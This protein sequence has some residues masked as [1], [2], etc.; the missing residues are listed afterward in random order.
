MIKYNEYVACVCFKEIHFNKISCNS[1]L[2]YYLN[3]NLIFKINK[4][5]I[6]ST[7]L[8]WIIITGPTKLYICVTYFAILVVIS[9][10]HNLKGGLLYDAHCTNP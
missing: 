3:N 10:I 6:V 2:N 8:Q 9:F 1:N 5:I 7:L 4:W